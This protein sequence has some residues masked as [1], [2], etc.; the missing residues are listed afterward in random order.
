MTHGIW[1]RTRPV[2]QCATFEENCVRLVDGF[3]KR[4]AAD[5]ARPFERISAL[6][7]LL[8]AA[9]P[10]WADLYA[11]HDDVGGRHFARPLRE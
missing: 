3:T 5:A 2:I 9:D 11:R 4:H 6:E 10:F 8:A 7:S 1:R